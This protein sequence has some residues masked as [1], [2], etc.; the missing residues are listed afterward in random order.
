MR[1]GWIDFSD[2]ERRIAHNIIKALMDSDTRDELGI[3]RIRDHFS[4]LF[5]P[6][7]SVIQTRARYFLFVPWIFRELEK[8]GTSSA[9]IDGEARKSE[10]R[11]MEALKEGED[12][13]GI[14][15][16]TSGK[17]LRRLPS[18]IYWLGLCRWDIFR[19]GHKNYVSRDMYHHS[20]DGIVGQRKKAA[21]EEKEELIFQDPTDTW[22]PSLPLEP[23]SLYRDTDF[24]LTSLEAEFLK[25]RIRETCE[26]TLLNHLVSNEVGGLQEV[27]SIWDI[28][29]PMPPALKEQIYHAENFSML[30]YGA[31]I[32]YNL[33]VASMLDDDEHREHIADKLTEWCD[34]YRELN[35]YNS[36]WNPDYLR[37]EV[38]RKLEINPR[39]RQFIDSWYNIA[40]N[41]P[42][43]ETLTGDRAAAD[44]IRSREVM[45]KGKKARLVSL[46]AR[47]RWSGSSGM[48]RLDF[49][50]GTVKEIIAD[51][52]EGL[53]RNA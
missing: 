21:D 6:G 9:D 25:E 43:A 27:G 38:L 1:F 29:I 36:V 4:N 20:F 28:E 53:S 3:G 46:E 33:Q 48:F 13:K 23:E 12:E 22:H 17:S 15:G 41:F 49:R 42:D 24:D 2:K 40:S 11:V 14:I 7:T 50:W 34:G 31:V 35:S 37:S 52:V 5:F 18:D 32:L 45:L 51:I 44:L 30:M 26:G 19:P 39:T 16:R 10:M 8:R 47:S